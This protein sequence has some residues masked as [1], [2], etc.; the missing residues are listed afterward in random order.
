MRIVLVGV[1]EDLLLALPVYHLGGV[2]LE[3]CCRFA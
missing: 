2:F 1:D 3:E